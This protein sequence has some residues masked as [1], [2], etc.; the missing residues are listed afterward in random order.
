M[1]VQS[2]N[3][4]SPEVP[5]LLFELQD[6]P[7]DGPSTQGAGIH[8]ATSCKAKG[9]AKV[10]PLLFSSHAT[11]SCEFTISPVLGSRSNREAGFFL[12]KSNIG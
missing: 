12:V 3:G 4:V 2:A 11:Q 6:Q 10:L 5:Q 1:L 7:I 9:G 8:A